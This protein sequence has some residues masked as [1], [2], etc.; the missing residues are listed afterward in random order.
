MNKVA[1]APF[2][3]ALGD[4]APDLEAFLT[5]NLFLFKAASDLAD[6][7][8]LIKMGFDRF[9]G[10]DFFQRASLALQQKLA[11]ARSIMSARA[12]AV[13]APASDSILPETKAAAGPP[14]K[15][16]V[17]DDTATTENLMPRSD[18]DKGKLVRNG[19]LV[20]DYRTGEEVSV[21]Y[22]TQTTN[23]LSN[24][25]ETGIYDVLERPGEFG[26]ML[27]LY[28]PYSNRGAAA[29]CT[30]IRLVDGTK[31]WINL[32]RSGIFANRIE[33]EDEFRTWFKA[34]PADKEL[35]AGG[36][37]VG[38][39][40]NGGGTCPFTV[41][42]ALGDGKFRVDFKASEKYGYRAEFPRSDYAKDTPSGP[43]ISTYNAL[44]VLNARPDTQLRAVSGELHIPDTFKFLSLKEPRKPRKKDDN[45]LGGCVPCDPCSGESPES[46]QAPISPGNISDIQT[47]FET[48]TASL[49]I[50]G[51]HNEVTIRT[52]KRGHE[53]LSWQEGLFCLITKHG[54][55]EADAE[56][57]LKEA[58]FKGSAVYRIKYADQY[59]LPGP[60]PTAPVFPSPEYGSEQV[61]YNTVNAIYPQQEHIP[62]PG[63]EAG[64]TD[65]RIYDPFLMPDRNAL[66]TAQQ[67]SES[68]QKEVF[69]TAMIG[70][71]L[72]SV[73]QDTMVDRHI[74]DLMKA[75]DRLG[76]LLM[77]FYWHQ[78]QFSDHYGKSELPE[79]ED[80]MRNAF[81]SLGDV[82]LFLK[83][84]SV[85]PDTDSEP[86]IDDAA[87][88]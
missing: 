41:L 33:L 37:Y 39:S 31:A 9:H 27:V 71:M 64:L 1:A 25:S 49:N 60:G 10:K 38:V 26:R 48:K 67:A 44:L 29:F 56:A 12:E 76:R 84:R 70:G 6:K 81:E 86:S 17:M 42:T 85:D 20:H 79:M 74:G 55:R 75:I 50:M 18:E 59:P 28:N 7:Y 52:E 15:I 23:A 51:D 61:G 16:E 5:S 24:P 46:D 30:V 53:R 77:N 78:E 45:I 83:E 87:K 34:L 36:T 4:I 11:D 63:L 35:K 8:P 3:A 68:G 69:D 88:A 21:A 47:L 66:M 80:A 62:V 13:T 73:R 54:L 40:A 43:Y 82:T 57:M 14:V 22:N 72:K 19:Y 32:H 58:Q 65:P 2:Q